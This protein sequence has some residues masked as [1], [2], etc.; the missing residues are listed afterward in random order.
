MLTF[1]AKYTHAYIA[2]CYQKMRPQIPSPHVL[3]TLHGSVCV[4]VLSPVLLLVFN[5]LLVNVT[6]P[7][8]LYANYQTDPALGSMMQ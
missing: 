6:P 7:I 3:C 1:C 4:C 8:R 2:L 5:T